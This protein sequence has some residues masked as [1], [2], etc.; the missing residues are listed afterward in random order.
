MPAAFDPLYDQIPLFHVQ[1][2]IFVYP[3]LL[4]FIISHFILDI[5][6]HWNL[7][8]NL[9]FLTIICY[10]TVRYIQNIQQNLKKYHDIASYL[11]L[12]LSI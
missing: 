7:Y 4:S 12:W 5:H 11:N 1:M 8:I 6:T 9:G 3:H 10:Q 2:P